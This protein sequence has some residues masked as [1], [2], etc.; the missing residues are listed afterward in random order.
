MRSVAVRLVFLP[1]SLFF[2]AAVFASA[3]DLAGIEQGIKPYGS[4][5]GGDIDFVSMVN[6]SLQVRIPLVSLPQRG[7]RVKVDYTLL[8]QNPYYTYT[9]NCANDPDPSC[10]PTSYV[11]HLTYGQPY[12]LQNPAWGAPFGI[13]T[14]FV[15]RS[16]KYHFNA[17][18]T[19]LGKEIREW[20]GALHL[21]SGISQ[22]ATGYTSTFNSSLGTYGTEILMDRYGTRYYFP[23]V[24]MGPGHNP[25]TAPGAPN[26]VEDVNGNLITLNSTSGI[27]TDTLGRQ[28]AGSSTSTTDYS[29]CTGTLTT[30]SAS[31]WSLP[32]PN[33][34]TTQFKF[35]NAQFQV[36]Y[37]PP[38]CGSG[39]TPI[40][41]LITT[42]QSVVLW[43]GTSWASSSAW[44]FALDSHGALSKVTLPTGG[45]ISYTSVV[46]T[47]GGECLPQGDEWKTNYTLV[48]TSRT[49]DANDGT[50][51][52][53]WTYNNGYTTA[54][55]PFQTV[56]TD[57]N[58][59]DTV[60]KMTSYSCSVYE[61]E[62]DQYSGSYT[63]GT[64]LK[65]MVTT[66]TSTGS[67]IDSSV[68]G[69]VPTSITT[70]DML[71]GKSS[72]VAMTYDPGTSGSIYG[73][74]LT[75]PL[76]SPVACVLPCGGPT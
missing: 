27:W 66:Y 56:V 48:T 33:G 37:T 23:Y 17:Q 58:L 52:H 5:E 75:H 57:P 10:I 74:V 16:L 72:Q 40:N 12:S 59:N 41:R 13:V 4:Y 76:P 26:K 55:L 20:D 64:L 42:T 71:S 21:L 32:A 6:G 1:I 70:T 68:S 51:P 43:N 44:T 45:S 47:P 31:I 73:N 67:S 34:G 30:V 62:R 38:G 19:I 28:L 61:T 25:S 22:D 36:N 46:A 3:Q 54:Y 29:G 49:V 11:Y 65:K 50:G 15:P 39:C 69:E 24:S 18:G 35:C 14:N 60:H 7:G 63:A 53:T 9:D 8:Y 2:M